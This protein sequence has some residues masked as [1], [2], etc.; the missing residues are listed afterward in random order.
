MQLGMP[1]M[2]FIFLL[3]LIIFGPKKLPEIGRQFGKALAE[4]KR[5]SNE[6]KSQLEDE[7]RQIEQEPATAPAIASAP[8]STPM[9]APAEGAVAREATSYSYVASSGSNGT[10]AAPEAA[11]AAAAASSDSNSILAPAA[12]VNPA[13][14]PNA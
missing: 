8:V 5:A 4:F 6:F 9:L 13:P 2:I 1:E 14:E 11:S 12:S 7:I 10:E 3:A